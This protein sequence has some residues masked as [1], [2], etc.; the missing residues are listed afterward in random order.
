VFGDIRENHPDIKYR[1]LYEAIEKIAPD[2]IAAAHAR[3][4]C[5]RTLRYIGCTWNEGEPPVDDEF[6][7]LGQV[8]VSSTFNGATYTIDDHGE[9]PI[10]CAYFEWLKKDS[11]SLEPL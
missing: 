10:G 7:K 1:Q 4:K 6:F 8:Y 2:Y 3:R 5:L 11:D 9:R